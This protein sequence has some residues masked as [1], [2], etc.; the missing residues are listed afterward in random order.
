M[1]ASLWQSEYAR[2]PTLLGAAECAGLVALY[3][4]RELFRS[5]IEMQRYRFAVGDYQYFDY[6]LAE[7]VQ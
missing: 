2:R 3:P 4:R 1:E 7:V 5:R 6:P